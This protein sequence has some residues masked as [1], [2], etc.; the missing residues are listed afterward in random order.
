MLTNTFCHIPGI[1]EIT[2]S[3]LWSA[4][5]VSWDSAVGHVPYWLPR[6]I[7]DIWNR[8]VDESVSNYELRNARHFAEKLE[9][10]QQWRLYRDF[11]DCCAFVDI[12]TTGLYL[13]AEITTIVLYDGSSIRHYVNGKNL[14]K[15]ARDVQDYRVLV[16]YNGGQFDLPRIEFRFGIKLTQ[17]HIDLRFALHSL[18]IRGGLKGC[19]RQ[20]GINRPGLNDVNG[21]M[22]V[23]LWH[24][25]EQ[26][27]RAK[28]LETLLAYNIQDTLSLHTLMVHAYNQKIRKTPFADSHVLTPPSLPNNPFKADQAIVKRIRGRFFGSPD[29]ME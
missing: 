17:A 2:E 27:G 18:G 21:Y 20:L 16:T 28:A 9:S 4:G 15:F 14:E 29:R 3:R 1:G 8:H 22:A 23:L 19:E 5:V 11:E 12:E 25:Y 24:E 26:Q 13:S 10:C 6:P 7:R